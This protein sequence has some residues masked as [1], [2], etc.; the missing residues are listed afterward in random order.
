[1]AVGRDH[2]GLGV[3]V[4]EL[5]VASG[6]LNGPD[7]SGAAPTVRRQPSTPQSSRSRWLVLIRVLRTNA[8]AR[9]T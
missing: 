5:V 1:M 3:A 4:S 7:L 2:G 8:S 9:G 6:W